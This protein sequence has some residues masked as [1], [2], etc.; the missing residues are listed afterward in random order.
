MEADQKRFRLR[1]N[2]GASPGR[3]LA[4][5]QRSLTRSLRERRGG[6]ASA[7]ARPLPRNHVGARRDCPAGSAQPEVIDP[8]LSPAPPPRGQ[9]G[10]RLRPE[11]QVRL[12]LPEV[13]HRVPSFPNHSGEREPNAAAPATQD[14]GRFLSVFRLSWRR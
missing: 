6:N 4:A 10:T 1:P 9:S 12:E 8:A 11:R 13:Q 7:P 3:R 2:E 5:L 14:V